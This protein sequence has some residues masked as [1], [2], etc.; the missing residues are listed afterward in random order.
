MNLSQTGFVG[1]SDDSSDLVSLILIRIIPEWNAPSVNSFQ[2]T[3][4]FYT[5]YITAR[6]EVILAAK[7]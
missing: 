7:W 5:V 6:I 2:I 1:S 4:S 3:A